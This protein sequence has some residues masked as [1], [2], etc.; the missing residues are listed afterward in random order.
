MHLL[1]IPLLFV[2]QGALTPLLT[3]W[4]PPDLLLLAALLSL[5]ERPLPQ[6]VALAYLLG[7]LQ[8][9]AGGGVIGVHALG[10]AAGVFVAGSVAGSGQTRP[11]CS[12]LSPR[13]RQ[14]WRANG[15]CSRCC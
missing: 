7:L 10:L 11:H 9:V 3:P 8:D 2:L 14:P 12:T 1:L 4:P 5:W 13:C 15:R 6:G